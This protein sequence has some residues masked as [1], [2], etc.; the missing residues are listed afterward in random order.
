M[1]VSL[2]PICWRRLSN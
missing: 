1:R 2:S